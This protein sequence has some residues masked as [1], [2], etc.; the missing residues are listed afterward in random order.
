MSEN[1]YHCAAQQRILRVMLA[2]AGHEMDGLSATEIARGIGQRGE[3][4]TVNSVFRDLHNLAEAGLA[5]QLPDSDRWRLAPRLVQIAAAHQ[6]HLERSA[7]RLA[8]VQQRY[9]RQP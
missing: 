8:E 5:E 6:R 9:S 3:S 1:K 2:L 7:Q 4:A